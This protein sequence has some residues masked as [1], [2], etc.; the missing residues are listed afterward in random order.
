MQKK[1][2]FKTEIHLEIYCEGT[3]GFSRKDHTLL[4][5]VDIMSK[6]A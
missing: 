4:I 3:E 6:G 1:D 2:S 5:T